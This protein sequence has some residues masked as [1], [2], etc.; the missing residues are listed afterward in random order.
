MLTCILN[1]WFQGVG[2]TGRNSVSF[3]LFSIQNTKSRHVMANDELCHV[4][5]TKLV[6]CLMH[7]SQAL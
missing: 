7:P 3:V 1:C 4:S 2:L 6:R 5:L